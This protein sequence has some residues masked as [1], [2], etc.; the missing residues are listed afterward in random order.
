MTAPMILFKR[1]SGLPMVCDLCSRAGANDTPSHWARP[2]AATLQR[3]HYYRMG[4]VRTMRAIA[5]IWIGAVASGIFLSL[6]IPPAASESSTERMRCLSIADVDQRV[7]CLENAGTSAQAAP[8]AMRRISPQEDRELDCRNP[9][10]APLCR[11]YERQQGIRS[12]GFQAPSGTYQPLAAQ[13]PV[14]YGT[15]QPSFNCARATTAIEQAICSDATLAQ[16]DARMG[17]L[18]RQALAIQNNSP[19]L[20]GDQSRWRALRNSNCSGT[21]LSD[22]KSCVLE[23]T[24]ARVEGLVTIVAANGENNLSPPTVAPVPSQTS[25]RVTSSGSTSVNMNA[26]CYQDRR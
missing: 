8:S 15:S 16:W 22:V 10:D 3:A 17:Q 1:S 21:N 5:I 19:T 26:A 12:G 13:L 9:Q 4:G 24:R 18:Y 14:Q 20:T 7:E 23:M 6:S 2:V 11:E 25:S